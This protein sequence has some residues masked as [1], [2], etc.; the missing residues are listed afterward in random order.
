MAKVDLV[1]LLDWIWDWSEEKKAA[2]DK[3]AIEKKKK[4][5]NDARLKAEKIER[6]KEKYGEEAIGDL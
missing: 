4:E 6:M 2:A 3:D 1:P 5:D